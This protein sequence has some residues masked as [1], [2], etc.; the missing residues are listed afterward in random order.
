MTGSMLLLVR[1]ELC[2]DDWTVPS[3]MVTKD[4]EPRCIA[5]FSSPHTTSNG[6]FPGRRP[7]DKTQTR[8]SDDW[9]KQSAA[10]ASRR[11]NA[12]LVLVNPDP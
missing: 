7:P 9:A 2:G 8:C 6:Y 5:T 11:M 10:S 1:T 3:A 4:S 12:R